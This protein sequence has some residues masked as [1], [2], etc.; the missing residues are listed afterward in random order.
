MKGK[1]RKSITAS[2]I[3]AEIVYLDP[4][5]N[6]HKIEMVPTVTVN[7][8]VNMKKALALVRINSTEIPPDAIFLIKSITESAAIYEMDIDKFLIAATLAL[9][10]D[11][12]QTE[13]AK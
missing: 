4:A 2:T 12:T 13:T 10:P 1:V 11:K 6:N 9:T 8:K 3:Q 7:G 5:T